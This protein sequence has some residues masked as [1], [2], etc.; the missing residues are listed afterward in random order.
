MCLLIKESPVFR[1]TT[2]HFIELN[3]STKYW[4]SKRV[5]F[6]QWCYIDNQ[7]FWFFLILDDRSIEINFFWFS[8]DIDWT[9]FFMFDIDQHRFEIQWE[10]DFLSILI[11][12]NNFFL[13]SIDIDLS[14]FFNFDIDQYWYYFYCKYWYWSTLILVLE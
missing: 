2:L 3:I 14:I 7:F 9:I 12:D 11:I 10:I 13:I 1:T 6:E 5:W 4:V 8:I